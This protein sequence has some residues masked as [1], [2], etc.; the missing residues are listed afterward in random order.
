MLVCLALFAAVVVVDASSDIICKKCGTNITDT[1]YFLSIRSDVSRDSTEKF[2]FHQKN[3]LTQLFR[4]PEGKYFEVVTSSR[5]NL[6]CNS[7]S[8][9]DHTFFKGYAWSPCVCPKCGIHHGW[10][11]LLSTNSDFQCDASKDKSCDSPGTFYGLITDDL[12]HKL[13]LDLLHGAKH[14]L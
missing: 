9:L 10:L 13:D 12:V 14:D 5:A 4:N 8:T 11:F 7:H 2:L 3:V 1:E 6:K